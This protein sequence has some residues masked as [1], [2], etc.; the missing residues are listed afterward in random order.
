MTAWVSEDFKKK[1]HQSAIDVI[2]AA[3][4]II[5]SDIREIPVD[6][7]SLE[8]LNDTDYEKNGYQRACKYFLNIFNSKL[9][10]LSF[11]QGIAQA[12]KPRSMIA[13]IPFGIGVQLDISLGTKWFVDH[14]AKSGFSVSSDEVK[15][16]KQSAVSV[17]STLEDHITNFLQWVA[18]N[19][20]RNI[21]TLTGKGTFH[22]M[23]IIAI[24]SSKLK[25]DAIK[26]LEHNN[27]VDLSATS[28]TMVQVLMVYQ[29]LN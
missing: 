17:N 29:R 9:K 18:D 19:V 21:R 10:Q 14:L 20:D 23:E 15:L 2:T 4:K 7:S 26:R 8:D 13:P 28:V 12:S 16:F 5:K 22:G 25:Y 11:G 6:K 24:S 27:K 3:A 1:S